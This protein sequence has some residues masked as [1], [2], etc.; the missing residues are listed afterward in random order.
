[1]GDITQQRIARNRG[2][3]LLRLSPWTLLLFCV[4]IGCGHKDRPG[5]FQGKP[6]RYW[7]TQAV[8]A[9][10]DNRRAAVEALGKIG[11]SG[12]RC[13][14]KLLNDGDRHVRARASLTVSQMG[15]IAV[16]ELKR[17]LN[18]P[19]NQNGKQR[20]QVAETLAQILVTMRQDGVTE[21]IALLKNSDSNIRLVAVRAF[22]RIGPTGQPA[23]P[24]LTALLDDEDKRV[25]Q[26][27]KV[28]LRTLKS[29][30]A[31]TPSSPTKG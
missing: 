13:L 1:M 8:S 17:L 25:R 28:A 7:E 2:M 30:P 22:L 27:A 21:L 19:T 15:S 12:L 11:P 16:P 14:V 10:P 4:F 6:L 26:A 3:R 31:V 18:A 29:K 24:T 5:E 23:I 20:M 9:N